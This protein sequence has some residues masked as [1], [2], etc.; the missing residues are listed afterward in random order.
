MTIRIICFAAC[1]LLACSFLTGAARGDIQTSTWIG[2][3]GN[4][5]TL[6]SW[7]VI[8]PS[9]A[10]EKIY[11]IDG[12]KA[13]VSNVTLNS[14]AIVSRVEISAAD[15]LFVPALR[16]LTLQSQLAVDG[17]LDL[18]SDLTLPNLGTERPHPWRIR[19]RDWWL[20]PHRA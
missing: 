6:S 13:A 20:Q 15:T 11:R 14:S 2:G 10:S 12:G 18:I 9:T 3:T 16:T 5:T 4:W 7:Q 1:P 8:G 19:Q 17:T